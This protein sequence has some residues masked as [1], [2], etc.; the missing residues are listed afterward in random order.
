MLPADVTRCH[1]HGAC[2]RGT[3]CARAAAPIETDA[4]IWFAAFYAQYGAQ[5]TKFVRRFDAA[6]NLQAASNLDA[7]RSVA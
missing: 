5:C 3:Y 4:H 1:D 2:P 7:N 6:D